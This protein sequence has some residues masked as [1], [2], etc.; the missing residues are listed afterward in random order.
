[1]RN[2]VSR[3][4]RTSAANLFGKSAILFVLLGIYF[5][6]SGRPASAA[7]PVWVADSSGAFSIMATEATVAGYRACVAAQAC[8]I[9]QVNTVCNYSKD[10]LLD[11][12][13]NC[14][15][16]YGAEQYCSFVDARVCTESEWLGACGGSEAKQFPYGT[17]FDRGACNV[18]SVEQTAAGRERGTSAA[19]SIESCEGGLS[20]LFDMA[21]NVSE[22]VDACKET[23]CKFRGGSYLTNEPTERFAACSG[24]CSGNQKSLQSGTVGF[25][26]CRDE[27]SLTP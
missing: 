5:V 3:I 26:C 18:G 4:G 10:E 19:G 16:Y 13:L 12:P 21:G 25:R 1:M 15:T 17:T 23:Y 20:G 9:E 6:A 22:W 7:E 27:M 24:V 11:H 8:E 14:V 2:T